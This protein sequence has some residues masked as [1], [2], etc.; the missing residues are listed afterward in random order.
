[1]AS[2]VPELARHVTVVDPGLALGFVNNARH[3]LRYV[4]LTEAFE[5][6]HQRLGLRRKVRVVKERLRVDALVP[7]VPKTLIT[8]RHRI[9]HVRLGR[10]TPLDGAIRWRCGSVRAAGRGE[11]I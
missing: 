5:E 9:V 3:H 1:M 10:V 8:P 2:L 7:E 4:N 11:A 6:H